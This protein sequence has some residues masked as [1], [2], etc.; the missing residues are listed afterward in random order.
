MY[1][2]EL[3][4]ESFFQQIKM[5]ESIEGKTYLKGLLSELLKEAVE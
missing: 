2:G 1:S 3:N 5:I 4:E